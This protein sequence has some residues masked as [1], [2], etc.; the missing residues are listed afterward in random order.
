MRNVSIRVFQYDHGIYLELF[1][2]DDK[3]IE[4]TITDQ[5]TLEKLK[6]ILEIILHDE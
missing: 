6:R 4:H 1:Y 3:N 5:L 2:V